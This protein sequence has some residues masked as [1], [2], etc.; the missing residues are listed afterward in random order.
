MLARSDPLMPSPGR[1]AAF[2]CESLQHLGVSGPYDTTSVS[3]AVDRDDVSQICSAIVAAKGTWFLAVRHGEALSAHTL[4]QMVKKSA[5]S[6]AVRH[7]NGAA[8]GEDIL[9]SVRGIVTQGPADAPLTDRDFLFAGAM[10][11]P[12]H[13]HQTVL[14]LANENLGITWPGLVRRLSG[15]FIVRTVSGERSHAVG[16][17]SFAKSR[18]VSTFRK[19][20]RER[21]KDKLRDEINFLKKLPEP[22]RSLYPAVLS[23][24]EPD[25]NTVV[26][27]QEFIDWPTVRAHLLYEGTD[28][29]EV[30][31]RLRALLYLLK[32][33]S[34]DVGAQ[35]APSDYIDRLHFR[36]VRQRTQLT[37]DL[38][39]IF[40]KLVDAR[41]VVINGKVYL[42]TPA[43]L[44]LFEKS[45]ALRA[46][47]T[48]ASVGPFVHGD[49]HFE[50]IL[51]DLTSTEFKLVDPR[52]YEL[53]DIYY[54]LGKLSHSVNG[55]YDLLHE[56]LFALD[57]KAAGKVIEGNLHYT[58]DHL[59]RT[60][61]LI[62]SHLH[63]WCA[64]LTG[65]DHS[66][67]RMLFNEA[68]HFA[69]DM[70]FHLA[71]DELENVAVAIYLTGVRLLNQFR[72]EWL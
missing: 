1:I 46:F 17:G 27:N 72:A 29:N 10:S 51:F 31:Q 22:L 23:T 20:A 38:S 8:A 2:G 25:R 9:R 49:L 24:D 3:F 12:P 61:D 63:L 14:R 37:C 21:G 58:N 26:M 70:P 39:P 7:R 19:E 40:R 5:V 68:M 56:H 13:I 15:I 66:L 65:D 32:R 47:A 43:I 45:A 36:R 44:N 33:V 71:H 55:K 42:N 53:C 34:Y 52:G 67:G 69:A 48:P 41:E 16:G 11:F 64:E 62:R 4:K 59:V 60:Y 54:D 50:N 6:V 30:V 18:V 28:P 35:S 57:Y